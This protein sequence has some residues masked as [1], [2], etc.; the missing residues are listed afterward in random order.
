MRLVII[1]PYYDKF[2]VGESWST[3]KWIEG[4]S[5]EHQTTILTTHKPG[6]DSQS[7]PTDA[8]EIVNW[9][10]PSI[11][12]LLEPFNRG[13]K[14][15][16]L[17]FYIRARKWLKAQLRAGRKI[18]LVHQINPLALRYPCPATG[19]EIPYLIGPLAGSLES[20]P[21]FTGK[22][23][24]EPWYRKLRNI[25]RFRLRYDPWLKRT[26]REART[27][28]GVAPYVQKL[29]EPCNI[30]GFELMSETGVD[31]ITTSPKRPPSNDEPLRL[32]FVGRIIRTKGVIDAIR[33]VA[34]ASQTCHLQFDIIGEGE[35]LQECEAEVDRL[36]I[37]DIVRFHGRIP[38]EEVNHWY[39]N[40]HV[41]LFPSYREPSGNVVFEAM[42]N[43]L[44]VITSATGGPGYV[45]NAQ[46]GY[47]VEPLEPEYFS[48]HIAQAIKDLS[49]NPLLIEQKSKAAIE[50]INELGLW[51][52]KVSKLL[53]TYQDILKNDPS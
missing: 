6:W 37:R 12:R 21:E 14:P 45:V 35:M 22:T 17:L 27:I 33:A 24:A 16:Y 48:K 53:Q 50:R 20:P 25:D 9:K 18:D 2:A 44:P 36:S 11:P 43:G 32:L 49:Q 8:Q 5:K 23:N 15:T 13:A 39:Q 30:K 7:S 41:F 42:G 52:R 4:I 19:L 10:E 3:Y 31:A 34:I 28:I 47:T 26:Y 38:R 29:L 40:A 1:A 51:S 46:T